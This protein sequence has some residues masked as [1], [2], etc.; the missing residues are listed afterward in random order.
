MEMMMIY[1]LE[2]R[3]EF[4]LIGSGNRWEDVYFLDFPSLEENVEF[5]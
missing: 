2:R 1:N 5:A 3:L 4:E